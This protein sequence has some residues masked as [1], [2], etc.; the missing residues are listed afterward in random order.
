MYNRINQPN[1]IPATVQRPGTRASDFGGM[2]TMDDSTTK[3]CRRCKQVK[4]LSEFYKRSG[5]NAADCPPNMIGHYLSECKDCMR[6]RNKTQRR[7]KDGNS[8]IY[9]EQLAIA[10]LRKQGIHTE[11]SR[12]NWFPHSD[13][14]CWGCVTLEVKYARLKWDCGRQKFT[15]TTTKRQ[16]QRGFLANYVILICEYKPGNETFHIFDVDHPVFYMQGRMKTG[17][18]FTPGNE[19][20]LKHGHNRV[21]MT[22]PLMD[23]AQDAFYLIETKR[24]EYSEMLRL[25][26]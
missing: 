23:A 15:F 5:Y 2:L 20:A 18:T 21:V 7:A 16:Q 11:A 14:V 10:H 24:Q 22:Q 3:T 25:G 1:E 8:L 26:G 12:R 17:F 6:E 13:I 19:R 4:P 9:H